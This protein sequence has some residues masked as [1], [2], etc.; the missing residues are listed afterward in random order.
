MNH[1]RKKKKKPISLRKAPNKVKPVIEEENPKEDKSN[2]FVEILIVILLIPLI[3]WAVLE[4]SNKQLSK[5]A[6]LVIISII[7]LIIA[8]VVIIGDK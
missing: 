7:F 6:T 1:R 4:G 3:I 8:G 5:R 2:K